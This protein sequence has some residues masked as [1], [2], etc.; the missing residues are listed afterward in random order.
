MSAATTVPAVAEERAASRTGRNADETIFMIV[1]V[2]RKG[3]VSCKDA[4]WSSG[5]ETINDDDD[6]EKWK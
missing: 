2:S 4:A 1:S 5:S 3:I 6:D